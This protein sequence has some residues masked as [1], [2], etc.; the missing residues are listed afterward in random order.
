MNRK[1]KKEN[2]MGY[3]SRF[4]VVEKTDTKSHDTEK[5]F[6]EIIA[7]FNLCKIGES[8][9]L[10]LIKDAPN[11][12]S[13]VYADD[14]NT[15]IFEDDHGDPLKEMTVQEVITAIEELNSDY[16]RFAPFIAFLK[17]LDPEKWRDLAILHYGY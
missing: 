5:T 15:K 3:E 1:K 4:Y 16:R 6:A 17:A 12:D 11:T 14:G 13:F 10:K 7:V 8:L 9:Y 2:D